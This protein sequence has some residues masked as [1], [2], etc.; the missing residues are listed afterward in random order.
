MKISL[1]DPKG[2]LQTEGRALTILHMLI[3]NPHTSRVGN[4][5]EYAPGLGAVGTDMCDIA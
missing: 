4:S 2:E 1:W 5:I 3:R